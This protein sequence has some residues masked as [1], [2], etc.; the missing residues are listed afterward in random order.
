MFDRVFSF[1]LLGALLSQVGCAKTASTIRQQPHQDPELSLPLK[2]RVTLKQKVVIH[3]THR[4][5]PTTWQTGTI[6]GQLTAWDDEMITI[7]APGKARVVGS[8]NVPIAEIEKID[9]VVMD[10]NRTL[11]V[12]GGCL[13]VTLMPAIVSVAIIGPGLITS[14]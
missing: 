7:R 9:V 2:V 12:I 13:L 5:K 4:G 14:L 1:I 10:R 8:H 11:A 6:S 3:G